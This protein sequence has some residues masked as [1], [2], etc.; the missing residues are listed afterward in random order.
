[1]E[2]LELNKAIDREAVKLALDGKDR[3][4]EAL[5]DRVKSIH[6]RID[7]LNK[8]TDATGW[9]ADALRGDTWDCLADALNAWEEA[10][11]E[12]ETQLQNDGLEE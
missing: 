9:I 11:D 4:L 6:D 1:M 7:K 2:P 8:V 10:V 5:Y 12:L 3:E